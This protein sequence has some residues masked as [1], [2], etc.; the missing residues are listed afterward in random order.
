MPT[1]ISHIVYAHKAIRL[2]SDEEKRLFFAGSV[3]PDIRHIG[4]IE[5]SGTHHPVEKDALRTIAEP[6]FLGTELHNWI[7]LERERV[8]ET[9]G[10]YESNPSWPLKTA[11]KFLEDELHY[12]DV[13]NWH[14]LSEQFRTIKQVP[15]T[16][17]MPDESV[18]Q[19]YQ[20]LATH[21]AARPSTEGAITLLKGTTGPTEDIQQ[22]QTLMESLR[23]DE[24]VIEK[25][26]RLI[27]NL[28]DQCL[29]IKT[30]YEIL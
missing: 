14:G 13:N 2:F 12:N 1:P 10:L 22:V 23:A 21:I 18:Q 4:A 16:P 3:F 17:A 27:A 29:E 7:D 15:S 5:R 30:T 28:T 11:T 9:I 25:I 6:F 19:W 8:A 24:I 26:H 20:L